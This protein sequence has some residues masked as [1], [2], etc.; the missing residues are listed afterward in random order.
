MSSFNINPSPN[1][2]PGGHIVPIQTQNERHFADFDLTKR[3]MES[4]QV[5]QGNS[6]YDKLMQS[7]NLVNQNII[8]ADKLS[9]QFMTKPNTVDVHD[10]TIAMEKAEMSLNLT[11]SVIQ[12]AI[13]A[14]QNIINLR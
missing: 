3:D 8:S 11:K 9:E 10:V 5:G 13:S 4:L 1:L 12:R 7:V 2:R 14:Y 6:F